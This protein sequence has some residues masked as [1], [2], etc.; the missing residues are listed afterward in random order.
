MS[1]GED[2]SVDHD[3]VVY[4]FNLDDQ[5][6]PVFHVGPSQSYR[7]TVLQKVEEMRQRLG[8]ETNG[9]MLRKHF[10]GDRRAMFEAAIIS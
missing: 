8:Y 10:G 5:E 7:E 4:G 9:E 3:G 6:S 1:A 2:Y